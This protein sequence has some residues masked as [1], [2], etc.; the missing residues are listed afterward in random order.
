MTSMGRKH[1]L[2]FAVVLAVPQFACNANVSMNDVYGTYSTDLP[3]GRATL[4][5]LQDHTWQYRLTGKTELS[6]SGTWEPVSK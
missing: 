4:I 6:R 3:D 5:I 2:L 1:R